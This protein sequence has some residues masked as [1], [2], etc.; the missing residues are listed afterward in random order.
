[1]LPIV[2]GIMPIT[3]AAQIERFTKMCGASIPNALHEQL[4]AVRE[5]EQ[6]V[7]DLGIEWATNQC[8]TLLDGGAPGVHFYTLNKSHATRAVYQNVVQNDPVP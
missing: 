2:P 4:E 6:A 7:V 5:D 1:G 8:R 3:N